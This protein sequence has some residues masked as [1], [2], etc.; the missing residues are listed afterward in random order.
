MKIKHECKLH[1][2]VSKVN[3]MFSEQGATVTLWQVLKSYQVAVC[4]YLS[5]LGMVLFPE[6]LCLVRQVLLHH[7]VLFR[8]QFI[9]PFF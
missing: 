4:C 8:S 7:Q 2:D 3:S 6:R 5:I 9:K 1:I